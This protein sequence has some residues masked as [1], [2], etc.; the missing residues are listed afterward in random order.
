MCSELQRAASRSLDH[1][2]HSRLLS[3]SFL[4]GGMVPYMPGSELVVLSR[5]AVKID[6]ID[7]RK[8]NIDLTGTRVFM[9]IQPYRN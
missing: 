9:C 7:L 1:D 6:S 4:R 5:S 2:T 8:K 3:M